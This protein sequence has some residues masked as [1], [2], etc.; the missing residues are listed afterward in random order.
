[1]KFIVVDE[2]NCDMFT[3][4]HANKED[5]LKDAEYQW[6]HLTDNEKKSHVVH[7]YVLESENPNEDAENHLDGSYIK[8]YK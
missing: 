8:Q 2:R 3:S 5:A 7:F 6:N 4:E 1:M